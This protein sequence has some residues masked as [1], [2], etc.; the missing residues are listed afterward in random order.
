MNLQQALTQKFAKHPFTYA[1]FIGAAQE[2]SGIAG[3]DV[4]NPVI[5]KGV[6]VKNTAI[7]VHPKY[8]T[9]AGDAWTD[10]FWDKYLKQEVGAQANASAIDLAI[11]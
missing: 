2:G 11:V 4:G 9:P 6:P 3:A 1:S 7:C 10:A 5:D 8:G